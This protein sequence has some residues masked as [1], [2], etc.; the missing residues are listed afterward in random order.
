MLWVIER[1]ISMKAVI[2][3]VLWSAQTKYSDRQKNTLVRD[4][5]DDQ[6]NMNILEKQISLFRMHVPLCC[7]ITKR[8]TP[9]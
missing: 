3:T 6:A 1:I 4:C 2:E 9:L 5:K 7:L 8:L